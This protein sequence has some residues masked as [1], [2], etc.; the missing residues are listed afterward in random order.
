M[1]AIL[2]MEDGL[3]VEKLVNILYQNMIRI[4]EKAMR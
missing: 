1:S 2:T 3:S 4:I